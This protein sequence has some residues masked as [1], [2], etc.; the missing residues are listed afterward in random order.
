MRIAAPLPTPPKLQPAFSYALVSCALLCAG[1]TL[2]PPGAG[3][4]TD[5][6]GQQL[7]ELCSRRLSRVAHHRPYGP[8][9]ACQK[10]DKT[11]T[12]VPAAVHAALSTAA[13]ASARR[14]QRK[15]R[16]VSDSGQQVEHT[17]DRLRV[18]APK[19]TLPDRAKQKQDK[20][21]ATLALLEQTHARRMAA[22]ALK[23]GAAGS[24]SSAAGSS[25]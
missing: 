10:H 25:H 6:D 18:R 15:R 13:A 12:A 3:P 20:E 16:A 8:G 11:Q 2:A 17:V 19:P 1:A 22:M 21:A 7:C 24:P 23:E 5:T 4:R 14:P 9:R